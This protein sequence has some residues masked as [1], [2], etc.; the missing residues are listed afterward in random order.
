MKKMLLLLL[1]LC[2]VGCTNEQ[3]T[4]ELLTRE[5]YSNI[6]TTGYKWFTCG[7]NDIYHTGF[8]AT[9]NNSVVTGT[10]C[11]GIFKGKT[12]RYD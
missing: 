7:G 6:E 4:E 12:I 3:S 8:K 1:V 5:G 9:K 10:V 2:F 11:E